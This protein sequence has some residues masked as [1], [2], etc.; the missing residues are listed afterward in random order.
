MNLI[1]L[2]AVHLQLAAIFTSAAGD[3]GPLRGFLVDGRAA[4]AF[5]RGDRVVLSVRGK[6]L[7]VYYGWEPYTDANLVNE[8]KLPASTF[9]LNIP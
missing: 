6:P 4:A 2:L 7:A 1:T 9:K 8:E 5:I 3:G